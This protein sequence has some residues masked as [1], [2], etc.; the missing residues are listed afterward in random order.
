MIFFR[1][2]FSLFLVFVVYIN[3][4]RIQKKSTLKERCETIFSPAGIE[5]ILILYFLLLLMGER[6]TILLKSI[7][8]LF[9]F[10]IVS[11]IVF[12]LLSVSVDGLR[13]R[14]EAK[15]V[16]AL[17]LLPNLLYFNFYW[18]SSLPVFRPFIVLC[19]D[20]LTVFRFIMI[21]WFAIGSLI[22]INSIVSHLRFRKKLDESL[23][24]VKDEH[25]LDLW[26]KKQEEYEIKESKRIR[27]FTSPSIS[28]AMTVGAFYRNTI[29]VLP[30]REYTDE[31]LD[32][33]F[34]HELVHIVREDGMTKLYMA[35][36][37]AFN[38]Y[39]PFVYLGTRKCCE[40]IELA[41]DE[42]VLI[43]ADEE[44]RKDYGKLILSSAGEG[45]GFTSNLSAD[46][47]SMKYRLM[48]ILKPKEK[49]KGA[50]FL[51]VCALIVLLIPDLFGV[52]YH[53]Q[54]AQDL[55]FSGKID[56]EK[57]GFRQEGY[58]FPGRFYRN[59][60]KEALI[61]YLSEIDV[62]EIYASENF[63]GESICFLY[64]MDDAYR[65]IEF[66]RH[67][68][69]FH[70]QGKVRTYYAKEGIDMDLVKKMCDPS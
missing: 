62:Y 28:S 19:I 15:T 57:G 47:E 26:N 61:S 51:S 12:S 70:D 24:E 48:N 14:Y 35:I 69:A 59:A 58:T 54:N 56:L 55:F 25:I 42:I 50:F 20:H 5:R 7:S 1:L 66:N 21:A 6:E 17:W 43:D 10:E 18:A 45:K 9:S 67:F 37:R 44:R 33:I 63:D 49:R 39:D 53:R 52:A 22:L 68:I 16:Y 23:Y 41:C 65:E 2:L 4:S 46:G 3:A 11:F 40:D 8:F 13:K 29:L 60:D 30:E 64:M 34:S 32:M 27:V 31:E 38:F 36:C